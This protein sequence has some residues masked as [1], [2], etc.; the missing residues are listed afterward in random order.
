[1]NTET[2][3]KLNAINKA[4]YATTAT[5]FDATRGQ[6]WPGWVTLSER[7]PDKLSVLDV[8]CG[9]GRF[10]VFLAQTHDIT[11]TGMDNN[12]QL[13]TYARDALPTATLQERDVVLSPPDV[14]EYDLVVAFG[15]LH[16][17]PDWDNRQQFVAALA[18][19]VVPGGWLAFAC[20]RFYEFPRFQRRVVAWP[21][22]PEYAVEHND[23]LLD[24][25]RGERALRYCHY[26]DDAEQTAL[27][28]ATGLEHIETYR[29][30]GFTGTV[31]AYSVL[32]RV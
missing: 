22:E 20:W 23:Y 10:G 31:N 19:R 32:R 28:A 5:D 1:M 7:L 14:G 24:W 26:V 27:E 2:I 18:A 16:H 12:A 4:F 15:L 21:P 25:R 9:N 3:K 6:P 13:L 30:D 11:Y 8:G 29:A 17:I